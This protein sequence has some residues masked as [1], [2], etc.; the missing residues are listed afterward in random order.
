MTKSTKN[1]ADVR[2]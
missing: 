1:V 2:F